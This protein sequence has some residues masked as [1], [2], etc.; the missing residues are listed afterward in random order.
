MHLTMGNTLGAAALLVLAGILVLRLRRGKKSAAERERERR[1][2]VNAVGRL[3]EGTLLDTARLP[4]DPAAS[5]LLFYRY[6]AA[7]V[8]YSAAQDISALRHL[9]PLENCWPG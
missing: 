2:A 7:G 8:E 3:T 6:S 9:A 4:N 5:A 1:L